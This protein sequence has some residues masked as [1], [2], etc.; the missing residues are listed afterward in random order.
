[1]VDAVVQLPVVVE[2]VLPVNF[3]AKATQTEDDLFVDKKR[4]YPIFE[5]FVVF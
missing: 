1:V 3:T 4:L 2:F 5:I